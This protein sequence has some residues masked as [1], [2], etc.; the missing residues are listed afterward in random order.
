MLVPETL[1]ELIIF[2]SLFACGPMNIFIEGDPCPLR[3]VQGKCPSSKDAFPL[4]EYAGHGASQPSEE[5]GEIL[6]CQRGFYGILCGIYFL[7]SI[8]NLKWA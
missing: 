6:P 3:Y 4:P 8:N 5:S 2:D 7:Y 1:G